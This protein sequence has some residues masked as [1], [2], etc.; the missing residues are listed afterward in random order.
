[1]LDVAI[2]F[3]HNLLHVAHT[4]VRSAVA[5]AS[6]P[7]R[8]HA[9]TRGVEHQEFAAFR[10][11]CAY[12]DK[13]AHEIYQVEMA[14]SWGDVKIGAALTVSTMDR[15]FLPP[16]LSDVDRCLY[17]DID[18][19]VL[20]DL[21]KLRTVD[22]GPTG[23]AA[24]A[25]TRPA[26]RTMN[27]FARRAQIDWQALEAMVGSNPRNFNAGVL[28]MSLET[29]RQSDMTGRCRALVEAT[30]CNDQLALVGYCE[31]AFGE[32]PARWNA[33]A[34]VDAHMPHVQ[35]LGVLHYV[36]SRKPWNGCKTLR[37]HWDLYC[38]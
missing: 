7:L 38:D 16:L 8:V 26:F 10:E 14:A 31:D 33:W 18:C 17:L 9:L 30:R 5:H 19:V 20:D 22:P 21:A 24:K 28:W 11:R 3:D 2:A 13:R 25:S 34:P 27:H 6:E 23:I 35:P 1:M 12:G 32:L 15:I 4:V 29:L 37:K 36:G